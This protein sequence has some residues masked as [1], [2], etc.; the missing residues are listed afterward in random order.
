VRAVACAAGALLALSLAS[1]GGGR[2]AEAPPEPVT[3]PIFESRPVPSPEPT[4]KIASIFPTLGRY[5]ISGEES[6]RGVQLAFEEEAASGSVHG[7]EIEILYYRT[8][9]EEKD[10]RAAAAEAEAAGALAII[11]SNASNLSQAIRDIAQ[12]RGIPMI[13]N[14]STVPDLTWDP[15]RNRNREFVF[16]VCHNDRVMGRFLADFA[17]EDLGAGKVAVLNDVSRSYSRNL[18]E[19]FIDRL[20]SVSPAIEVRQ[21]YYAEYETDFRAQILAIKKFDPDVLF[22]PGSFID[23]SLIAV[24]STDLG[25]EATLLGGDSWS[26]RLLFSRGRPPGPS[27]HGDH[28]FV[29][30]PFRDAYEARYG[31]EP[32][33]GRAALAHDA[34]G[35]LVTALRN[36]GPLTDGDLGATTK[37]RL[38]RTRDRLRQAL[39]RSVYPGVTGTILFD[40]HGDPPQKGV[41]VRIE[42][43]VRTLVKRLNP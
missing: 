31:A 39:A 7:R 15:K 19:G 25:L 26:N 42:D 4:L 34:F 16:R 9:S 27:Y 6:H 36:L 11:G 13:S 35:V 14:V 41:I 8:G 20:A 38:S 5:A 1:C 3:E 28:W 21:Y 32:N 33:G 2:S 24:Q 40:E 17:R 30:G 43:G 29:E 12:I 37:Q 23:A 22:V 18:A 10:V